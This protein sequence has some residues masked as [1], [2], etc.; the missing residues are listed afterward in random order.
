[1]VETNI[2]IGD[3]DMIVGG[4]VFEPNPELIA[5]TT[6]TNTLGGRKYEVGES[7]SDYPE[8]HIEDEDVLPRSGATIFY[9]TED[10]IQFMIDHLTR[11]KENVRKAK[12]D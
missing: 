3:G 7:V 2:V 1:M 9:R 6:F 5:C 4:H 11:L 8:E 12:E 10:D